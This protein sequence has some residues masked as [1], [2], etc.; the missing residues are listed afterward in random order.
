MTGDA[1]Q[2]ELFGKAE[3][4]EEVYFDGT[5]MLKVSSLAREVFAP[6][7]LG[8]G[9][10]AVHQGLGD[11]ADDGSLCTD[12]VSERRGEGSGDSPFAA[13]GTQHLR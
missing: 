11:K 3:R 10:D 4:F 6:T 9:C 2:I 1:V 12:G 13:R 7:G 5:M 8:L